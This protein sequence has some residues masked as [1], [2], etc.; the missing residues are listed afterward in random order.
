MRSNWPIKKMYCFD[1]FLWLSNGRRN[2]VSRLAVLAVAAICVACVPTHN[3]KPLPNFVEVAIE[4]VLAGRGG[5]AGADMQTDAPR[6]RALARHQP[7]DVDGP[8]IDRI[9]GR[10]IPVEEIGLHGVR[11]R[12]IQPKP[13]PPS[14]P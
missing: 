1:M 5:L 12:L 13:A 14:R 2:A 7:L 3:V 8:V 4:L 10:G 6:T 9:P 11:S